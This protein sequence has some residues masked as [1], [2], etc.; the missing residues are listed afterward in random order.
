M[1]QIGILLLIIYSPIGITDSLLEGIEGLCCG[2]LLSSGSLIFLSSS[3]S[4]GFLFFTLRSF[5][6]LLCGVESV[7]GSSGGSLGFV[8]N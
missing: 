2:I 8:E 6:G 4:L 7:D 3:S 5:L 1:V